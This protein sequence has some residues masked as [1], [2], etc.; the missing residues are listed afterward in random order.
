MG[1]SKRPCMDIIGINFKVAVNCG[2]ERK[3]CDKGR[4]CPRALVFGNMIQYL[5][6]LKLGD[7]HTGT[8]CIS[9]AFWMSENITI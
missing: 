4:G 3:E 2:R 5:V 6:F 8:H 1:K 7:R 9:Y